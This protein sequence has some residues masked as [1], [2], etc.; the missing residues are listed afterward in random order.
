MSLSPI[1]PTTADWP[2]GDHDYDHDALSPPAEQH[3]QAQHD[4][5]GLEL[6]YFSDEPDEEWK[7]T[8]KEMI[9][10]TL[11]PLIA[12]TKDRLERVLQ[13]V[14]GMGL[15]MDKE[16]MERMNAHYVGVFHEC[17]AG[18]KALAKEELQVALKREMLQ[19]RIRRNLPVPMMAVQI[20]LMDDDLMSPST[21]REPTLVEQDEEEDEHEHD[22]INHVDIEQEQAATL[23]AATH[24]PGLEKVEETFQSLIDID[25]VPPDN[26]AAPPPEPEPEPEPDAQALTITLTRLPPE[27][28]E[29]ERVWTSASSAAKQH[30]ERIKQQRDALRAEALG[31]PAPP[32]KRWVS[33]SDVAQRRRMIT[34]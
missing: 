1:S 15:E 8:R 10:E 19:R 7:A 11:Q 14:R 22:L 6:E 12:E 2:L 28:P 33:A 27:I 18:V 13:N 16:E 5:E 31:P 21:E 9:A 29:G 17:I 4:L 32:P 30:Q 26:S 20:D 23:R 25:F 3:E 34:G 24:S